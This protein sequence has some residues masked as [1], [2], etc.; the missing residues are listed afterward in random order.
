[1]GKGRFFFLTVVVLFLVCGGAAWAS[2]LDDEVMSQHIRE[3]D[4][5]SGQDTNT[6]SGIKTNH[7][8]NG[9]VTS[10]KLGNNAVTTGKIQ[11]SAITPPKIRANAIYA[12]HIAFYRNV[13]IV[14]PVGGDFTS[15]VDA[16]NSIVDASET[17]PYLVKIMP[18]V[19]D[20]GGASVQMQ[21]YVDIE[22]SGENVT[23]I[24][25]NVGVETAGVVNASSDAELRLFTV[26]NNGTGEWSIGIRIQDAA[27]QMTHVSVEVTGAANDA[28]GIYNVTFGG[29]VPALNDV[30]IMMS[31]GAICYG[32]YNY[33]G[34]MRVS[35][36]AILAHCTGATNFAFFNGNNYS[37]QLRRSTIS[38]S[39]GTT[40]YSLWNAGG[41]PRIEGSI[42]VGPI[43]PE[44]GTSYIA[45]TR[46]SNGVSAGSGILRCV[47]AYD[48]NFYPLGA[49]CL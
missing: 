5:T 32:M 47:G 39:G 41:Y 16:M 11:N 36:S 6:G 3:A 22:G 30:H 7:I 4:G 37:P 42:M 26:E 28:A 24:K 40:N 46:V 43:L 34:N 14:A 1:M 15:P 23:K 19:Y 21:P 27:L 29:Q 17:N 13:I 38:A 31:G 45:N 33:S 18:G 8:Q 44:G 20:I 48:N 2:V 9:A 35:E 12:A 49:D 10:Q 25:G